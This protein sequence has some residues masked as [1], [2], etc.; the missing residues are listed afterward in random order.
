MNTRK[1]CI[2]SMMIALAAVCGYI[3]SILPIYLGVP[4]AKP[5]FAN[6]VIVLVLYLYGN[7]EAILCNLLRILIVGFL[8]GSLYSILYSITGAVFSISAMALLR[9]SKGFTMIGVSIAG[10]VMHNVGQLFIA[11]IVLKT[12]GIIFYLPALLIAGC[13]T[14]LA[15]GILDKILLYP[16]Q[17]IVI[18]SEGK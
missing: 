1:I 17:N 14:G 18:R 15:V 4:G 3:E 5:G 2:M 11:A 12:S 6:I 8:F 9:K 16:I 10:G 7:R 13:I